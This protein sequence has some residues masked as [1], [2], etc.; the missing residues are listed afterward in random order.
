MIE[1]AA[2]K[3]LCCGR[4]VVPGFGGLERRVLR[5]S[6]VHSVGSRLR[7][8]T[9]VHLSTRPTPTHARTYSRIQYRCTSIPI[10]CV[11]ANTH[12]KKKKPRTRGTHT[13]THKHPRKKRRKYNTTQHAHKR[14]AKDAKHVNACSGWTPHPNI[15]THAHKHGRTHAQARAGS[16]IRIPLCNSRSRPRPRPPRTCH[17]RRPRR[18]RRRRRTSS[19]RCR[20]RPVW[21]RGRR[22]PR[23]RGRGSAQAVP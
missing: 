4:F 12:Q 2:S 1:V 6:S 9:P 22:P 23:R 10:L 19:L 7:L 8:R 3:S 15:Q 16:C 21:R 17:P 5:G 14:H 11:T 18:P 20:C 13:H